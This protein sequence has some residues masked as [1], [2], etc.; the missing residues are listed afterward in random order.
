MT[1]IEKLKKL[2]KG[3]VI[4]VN[5]EDYKIEDVKSNTSYDE[6]TGQKSGVKEIIFSKNSEDA[7]KVISQK[8]FVQFNEKT[9]EV[10]M[11]KTIQEKEISKN[12]LRRE[13][14][15]IFFSYKKGGV[16]ND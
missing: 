12:G 13:S 6:K 9:N 15:K 16:K 2:K 8:H 3:E 5:N 1:T 7:K 14:K 4:N 11:M 10:K